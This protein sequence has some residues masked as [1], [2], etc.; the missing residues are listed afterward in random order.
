MSEQQNALRHWLAQEKLVGDLEIVRDELFADLRGMRHQSDEPGW[1]NDALGSLVFTVWPALSRK[2]SKRVG[3]IQKRTYK[4]GL[5]SDARAQFDAYCGIETDWPTSKM[6][7]LVDLMGKQ[8]EQAVR[9]LGTATQIHN[10][11]VGLVR[12]GTMLL[13]KIG[14]DVSDL[15]ASVESRE[16]PIDD[17]AI[18]F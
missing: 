10:T 11:A 14:E 15:E 17:N 6:D 7:D 13:K 5:V 9:T 18:P 8:S 12:L 3:G 16:P 2:T 4:F 1:T